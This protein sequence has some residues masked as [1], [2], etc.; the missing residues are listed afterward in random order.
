M[1]VVNVSSVENELE[2]ILFDVDMVNIVT[3]AN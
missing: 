1:K 3:S 2:D